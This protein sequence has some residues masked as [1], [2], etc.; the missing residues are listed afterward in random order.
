MKKL[1]LTAALTVISVLALSLKAD[2]QVF[3]IKRITCVSTTEY[4]LNDA[5]YFRYRIG[6]GSMTTHSYGYGNFLKFKDGN[7]RSNVMTL[8]GEK[9]EI[10]YIEVWEQNAFSDDTLLG[11]FYVH[12]DRLGEKRYT[13]GG[14]NTRYKYYI[15]Y[16]VR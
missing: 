8:V 6:N 12:L 4:L 1:L 11:S 10:I 16:I 15:D 9:N 2:A 5:I 13:L 7:E 14:D 3:N